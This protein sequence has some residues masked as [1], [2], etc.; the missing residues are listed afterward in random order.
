MNIVV[1][2]A[3]G[4][5]GYFGGKLAKAGFKVTFIARGKAFEAIKSKGLQVKSI[6]GDFVV[7]PKVT[8][9]ISE[10][11]NPDLVCNI[12]GHLL[13]MKTR[14]AAESCPL[15]KWTVHVENT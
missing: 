5:G 4:V 1:Y 11:K 10:I 9:D 8:D 15:N 13:L 2:G 3:G 6:Y 14:D 7:H 12:N